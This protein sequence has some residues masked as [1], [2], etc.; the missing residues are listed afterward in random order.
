[1][2]LVTDYS[3][4][5]RI[6]MFPFS[7]IIEGGKRFLRFLASLTSKSKIC[8]LYIYRNDALIVKSTDAF[9]D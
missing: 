9:L 2:V 6:F 8:S 5:P 3:V 4:N 7:S 1:M